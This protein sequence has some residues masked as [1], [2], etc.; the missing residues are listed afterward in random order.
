MMV[1]CEALCILLEIIVRFLEQS[2]T[3]DNCM[4]TKAHK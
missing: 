3:K 4:N 1:M 2:S